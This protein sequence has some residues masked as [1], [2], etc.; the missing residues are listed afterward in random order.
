MHSGVDGEG[1]D[2]PSLEATLVG[3][4]RWHERRDQEDP[5]A[6]MVKS[7]VASEI[8]D[9]VGPA[10]ADRILEPVTER[11]KLFPAVEP[12]LAIFLGC[13]AAGRLIQRV[14]ESAIVRI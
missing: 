9:Y 4:R 14:I 7:R 8:A 2:Q 12:V 1:T 11:A 6:R 3:I 5:D 10:A 13:R